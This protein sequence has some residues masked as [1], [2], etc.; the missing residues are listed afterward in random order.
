MSKKQ[1]ILNAKIRVLES[2]MNKKL[3]YNKWHNHVSVYVE[4]V[5]VEG[6]S[7]SQLETIATSNTLTDCIDQLQ[8][9]INA[10]Y[11]IKKAV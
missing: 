2:L 7:G 11:I 8:A 9:A 3:N 6:D 5:Y 10:I 4:G 1:E